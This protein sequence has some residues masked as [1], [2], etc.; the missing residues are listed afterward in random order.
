MPDRFPKGAVVLNVLT[1]PAGLWR[2]HCTNGMLRGGETI[3]QYLIRNGKAS[4]RDAI[5]ED[6]PSNRSASIPNC[7]RTIGGFKRVALRCII[8][9][10][11][12]LT[13]V[14]ITIRASQ[15]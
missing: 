6:S 10:L 5:A 13:P 4:Q 2:E 9:R 7:K 11:N 3:T 12:G 14:P 15:P 1:D 8:S